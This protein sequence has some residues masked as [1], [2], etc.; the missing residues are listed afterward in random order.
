M[1]SLPAVGQG[2]ERRTIMLKNGI[3]KYPYKENILVN[4]FFL[5]CIRKGKMEERGT[6]LCYSVLELS[7]FKLCTVYL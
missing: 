4:C 3:I 7:M 5:S 2:R 6:V 1:N